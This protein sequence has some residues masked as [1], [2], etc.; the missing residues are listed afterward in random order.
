MRPDGVQE[1]VEALCDELIV[2]ARRASDVDLYLQSVDVAELQR[3]LAG[4]RSGKTSARFVM[5]PFGSRTSVGI[6]AR[7]ASSSR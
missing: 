4:A 5:S 1:A 2:N 3:K 6:P 7:S